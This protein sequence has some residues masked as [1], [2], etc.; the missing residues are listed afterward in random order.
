MS[1]T[2][3]YGLDDG[4]VA[5]CHGVIARIAP[6]VRVIDVAHRVPP[7]DIRHGS[8]ILAQTAP[9]LP[10]AVHVAV[11]D[12]GV[13][14]T[15]RGVVIVAGESLLV[16]PD[17]G[18]LVPAAEALGGIRAAYD[19]TERRYWLHPEVPATFHGRDIFAPAGAHLATGV[20]PHQ[21]GAAVA[22]ADLVRL[23]EPHVEVTSGR[24]HADILT[25]DHFGNLQLA[26]TAGDL[27]AA[28]LEPGDSITVSAGGPESGAAVGRTFAD[29]PL[30]A[31]VLYPD[32]VGHIAVA[33]NSGSAA[34]RLAARRNTT[35]TVAKAAG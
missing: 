33:V 2:T 26:A 29:V 1:F 3:D 12:P 24:I 23:P 34:A 22:P 32:A 4:F 19:L 25:I 18:L 14:T 28:G 30:D 16:G 35:M 17:N 21:L 31:L 10:P 13:G 27:R 9:Y 20:S 8:A 7:Q 6:Q 5:A 11:I 15:R